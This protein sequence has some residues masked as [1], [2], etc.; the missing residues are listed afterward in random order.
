MG[1]GFDDAEQERILK[2]LRPLGRKTSSFP[3]PPKMPRVRKD[4]VVWVEPRVVAQVSFAERTHD[5]RLRAPVYL[6][7]R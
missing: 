2:R 3:K 1:T 7:L 5:N 6:G 4:D